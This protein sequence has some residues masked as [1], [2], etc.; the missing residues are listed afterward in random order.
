MLKNKESCFNRVQKN[1]PLDSI[2][3]I[4]IR[5]QKIICI[6][7]TDKNSERAHSAWFAEG[8]RRLHIEL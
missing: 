2:E 1:L 7:S 6:Y 5:P 4:D 8:H 3:L